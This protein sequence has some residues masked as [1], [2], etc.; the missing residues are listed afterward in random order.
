MRAR[1][2]WGVLIVLA[3]TVAAGP[4][5][6]AQVA[7]NVAAG[8]RYSGTLVHDSI[9]APF[10][11]RP[12]IAP[13]LALSVALAPHGGW[14]GEA[15]LDISWS[16]LSR[17]DADG[18]T[19]SL[20]GLGA[21]SFA[22]ALHRHLPAGFGA[23]VTAGGLAYLPAEEAGV[24]REGAEVF[25]LLGLG[26]DYGPLFAPWLRIEARADAH[27][28]ITRALRD[29]GFTDRRVVPRIALLLRADLTRLW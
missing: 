27:T 7:V 13:A 19:Q 10:D 17:H 9:V 2:R 25:P 29:V 11:V 14:S 16:T 28:F 21:L 26:V 12:G 18:T 4:E 6:S 5:S 15:L 24:F 22:V 3:C 1:L 8:A 20:G 23:R